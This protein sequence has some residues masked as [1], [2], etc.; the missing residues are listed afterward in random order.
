M[1]KTLVVLLLA[2]L[3][4]V[5]AAGAVELSLED[6]VDRAV[7]VDR[8]YEATRVR[9][10]GY[11]DTLIAARGAFVP[12]LDLSATAI[13]NFGLANIEIPAGT[14]GPDSPA[15]E[16]PMGFDESAEMGV[17]LTQ[18]IYLAGYEWAGL[19]LAHRLI[20][21]GAEE[22]RGAR[23]GVIY[24]TVNLYYG[25]LLAEE[26]LRVAETGLAVATSHYLSAEDRYDAG[27]VSEYDVLRARVEVSNL[28]TERD[29]ASD[30]VEA[31]RRA[32]RNQLRL[33][34]DE[35]IVLTDRMEFELELFDLDQA[36]VDA[37]ERR[38]ELLQL[39]RNIEVSDA[40]TDLEKTGDN[41]TVLLMAGAKLYANALSLDKDEWDDQYN[42][43]LNLSW[44]IWDGLVTHG[45][46]KQ[47][48]SITDALR[49]EREA[50]AD[51]IELE[52]KGIFDALLTAEKA[53]RT[54]EETVTMAE[55]GLE[56]AQARYDYGLMSNLEVMDAQS[57]LTQARLGYSAALYDYNIAKLE[58]LRATGRIE[59]AY[60]Y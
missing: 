43:M 3:I 39:D 12:K 19:N 24:D 13:K 42:V 41:P 29:R 34:E 32:L 30:G 45:K 55:R 14:F 21:L 37:A 17:T 10:Q 44:P 28:E 23:E 5:T 1:M 57:A 52:V 35:A 53:V 9:T 59:E 58:M 47:K 22:E 50:A 31:A 36:L 8:G 33:G 46:V 25:L 40:Y 16:F 7:S 60:G 48:E 54:S 2:F 26:S 18:P 20:D 49:I 6:A 27:L 11:R 51:G 15:V 56:I 38:T 4:S